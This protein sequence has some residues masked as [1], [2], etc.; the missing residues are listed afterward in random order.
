MMRQRKVALLAKLSARIK[1]MAELSEEKAFRAWAD[2]PLNNARLNTIHS[3]HAMIPQFHALLEK[4]GGNL[5]AY[6]KQ[7]R[8]LK[9]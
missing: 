5:D 6:F 9:R 1:G 7:V 4:C 3:Y 2:K 8:T